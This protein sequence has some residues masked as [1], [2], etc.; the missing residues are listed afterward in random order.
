M[1]K[2]LNNIAMVALGLSIGF[3][4]ADEPKLGK[5]PKMFQA[6]YYEV[7]MLRLG[8]DD[9]TVLIKVDGIDNDFDGQI[10]LHKK[11][12]DNTECTNYKYETTEIPGKTRWWTVQSTRSWG[13]YDNMILYPPGI[14]KKSELYSSSRP[15]GFDSS[16]FYQ[17]Y[18]GQKAL[19]E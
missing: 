6:D 16:A 10:F 14:N 15:D 5:Y 19:R 7:T 4:Q 2:Q 8:E 11:L 1:R 9:S 17:E 13:D 18:L 3:A 12:C